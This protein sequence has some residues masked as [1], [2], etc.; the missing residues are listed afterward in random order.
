MSHFNVKLNFPCS[1]R[2]IAANPQ[3]LQ[4]SQ[5]KSSE[6]QKAFLAAYSSSLSAN[7]SI[8]DNTLCVAG[9]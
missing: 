7:G 8:S 3:L 2:F 5:G 6:G 9:N 4:N 1:D